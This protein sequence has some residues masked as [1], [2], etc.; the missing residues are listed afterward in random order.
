MRQTYFLVFLFVTLVLACS[1][2]KDLT[3]EAVIVSN[4]YYPLR[5]GAFKEY[6]VYKSVYLSFSKKDT[7]YKVKEVLK[8]VITDLE[9]ET[10]FKIFRYSKAGLDTVYALDSVWYAKLSN[11]RVVV[12]ENNV[13]YVKISY[14]LTDGKT[15]NGNLFNFNGDEIYT[16]TSL[17][18]PNGMY[19]FTVSILQKNDTNFLYRNFCLET[20]AKEIGL[21]NKEVKVVQF[22]KSPED[23]RKGIIVDGIIV[24]QRLIN[25]GNE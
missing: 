7:I 24:K 5:K 10:A 1:K 13:P 25:Y 20:Y 11:G 19:P 6:E 23:F 12:T 4:D 2:K 8:E 9:G 21:V 14:P 16:A 17:D 18:K 15:W 3:V 22:S